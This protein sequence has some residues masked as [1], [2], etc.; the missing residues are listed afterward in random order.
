MVRLLLSLSDPPTWFFLHAL[1]IIFAVVK[2][3]TV[4]DRVLVRTG[5]SRARRPQVAT[6]TI[7]PATSRASQPDL[8]R[9]VDFARVFTPDREEDRA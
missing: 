3:F 1:K 6:S 4:R 5:T 2:V 8:V 7:T 9:E